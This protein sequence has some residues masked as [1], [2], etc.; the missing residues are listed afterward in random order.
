MFQKVSM[1]TLFVLSGLFFFSCNEKS[2]T[3]SNG[4]HQ[5]DTTG[6]SKEFEQQIDKILEDS[7]RTEA[8]LDKIYNDRNAAVAA[9]PCT[10]CGRRVQRADVL[11]CLQAYIDAMKKHGIDS[12]AT[13]ACDPTAPA[14]MLTTEE[15]FRGRELAGFLAKAKIRRGWLGIGGG[16]RLTVKVA[17]GLYTKE[18]LAAVGDSDPSK[19][20]RIAVFLITCPRNTSVQQLIA[21]AKVKKL[22]GPGDDDPE[23]FDFGG[24]HP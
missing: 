10:D 24:L 6:F 5:N 2:A 16:G 1:M 7:A 13:A 8:L 20:G 11:P 3:N 22:F 17:L 21:E 19:V 9:V 4:K 14:M 12:T 18:Y 15:V 23:S